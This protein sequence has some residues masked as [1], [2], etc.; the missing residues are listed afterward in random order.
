ME[1]TAEQRIAEIEARRAERA[2]QLA[3]QRVEQYA[4]D[5]EA[6]DALE[7]KH[8]PENVARLDVKR[9]VP[10]HP[11]FVVL[12]APSLQYYRRFCDQVAK[13]QG[14]GDAKTRQNAQDD[15]AKSC[16]V[17]PEEP[18]ARDAMLEAF[19]GLLLSVC[20]KAVE[21]VEAKA[22]EEGKG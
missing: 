15:L 12:K 14:S 8:G 7:A 6:L 2:E 9:Y 10:G 21:L 5:M 18:K 16:W 22:A 11:T 19:P 4:Q 1:K 3:G 13:A 17:Y 20:L